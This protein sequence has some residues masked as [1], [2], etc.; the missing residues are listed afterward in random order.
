[1]AIK[2][3]KKKKRKKKKTYEN[4]KK[5]GREEDQIEEERHKCRATHTKKNKT[6]TIF[7]PWEEK[8]A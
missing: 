3:K 5:N 8:L 2:K 1:M 7:G 6:N 4:L